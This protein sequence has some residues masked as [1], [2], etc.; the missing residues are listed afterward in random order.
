MAYWVI[1]QGNW[2]GITVQDPYPLAT[3]ADFTIIDMEG[4]PPDLNY[5]TFDFATNTFVKTNAA[6]LSKIDFLSRFTTA[7]RV[8][9]HSSTDLIL[10]DAFAL[11]QSVDYVDLTDQRTMSLVGYLAMTGV[12]ADTRVAEILA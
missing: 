9:V 5:Y 1:T 11:L 2:Y 10:K 8:A 3:S 7:E 12:I 6:Q 4:Q